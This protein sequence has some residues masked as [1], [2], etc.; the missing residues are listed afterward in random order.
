MLSYARLKKYIEE[1]KQYHVDDEE[2][3]AL[4]LYAWNTALSAAFYG[5]LQTLEITLR[6][7]VNE[8]LT[9][10]FGKTWY[11]KG[12]KIKFDKYSVDEIERAKKHWKTTKKKE[13][14]KNYTTD[15]IVANISLG[16]WT[17][18]LDRDYQTL[19]QSTTHKAFQNG[20]LDKNLDRGKVYFRLKAI[21]VLRNRI[22]HHEPIFDRDLEKDLSDILDILDWINHVAKVWV[23]EHERLS[24]VLA[25]RPPKDTNLRF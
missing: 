23:E 7:A 2:D 4:R 5:P 20:N 11:N 10:A 15:D 12:D 19:W 3:F 24:D 6:N 22:A 25:M 17:N 16:F 14:K 1:A 9:I 21:H 8:Q 18:L 13:G